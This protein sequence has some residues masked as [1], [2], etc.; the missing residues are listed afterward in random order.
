MTYPDDTARILEQTLN[1][2]RDLYREEGLPVPFPGKPSLGPV[3]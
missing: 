3:P 1:R 2:L